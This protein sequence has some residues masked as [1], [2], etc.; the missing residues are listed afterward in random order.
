LFHHQVRKVGYRWCTY[1]YFWCWIFWLVVYWE[2]ICSSISLSMTH[3]LNVFNN[4]SPAV[5]LHNFIW[6]CFV[7]NHIFGLTLFSMPI[8]VIYAFWQI[9]DLLPIHTICLLLF[10]SPYTLKTSSFLL[11]ILMNLRPYPSKASTFT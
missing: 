1:S 6:I 8:S 4:V 2:F 11:C 3:L 9:F 5:F 10:S 7:V